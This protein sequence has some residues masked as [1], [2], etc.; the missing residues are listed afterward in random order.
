MNDPARSRTFVWQDPLLGA[1]AART[2]NGLDYLA[3]M[4]RG[5]LPY[6]PIMAALG[7][8]QV[9]PEMEPGRVTFFL[10]PQEYHYNPIGSVHGGVFATLLDS[11]MGCAVHS[12]LPAGTGYTTLELKVNFVR[13]L[14]AGSGLV[15][16][17]G[18]VLSLGRQVATAEGRIV[19]AAGKLYAHATT[20]CLLLAGPG[21]EPA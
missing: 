5:E 15:R 2:L 16:C 6:P 18:L 9:P 7:F 17:E 11:A 14:R 20:T 13:P 3:A 19:D 10:E 21:P 4:G 1:R 12:R 8:D